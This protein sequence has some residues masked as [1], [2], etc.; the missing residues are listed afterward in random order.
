MRHRNS[1]DN[2]DSKGRLKRGLHYQ[3]F[4]DHSRNLHR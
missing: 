2:H 4:C 1:N 3:S